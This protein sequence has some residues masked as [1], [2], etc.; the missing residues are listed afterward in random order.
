M[1]IKYVFDSQGFERKCN[2]KDIIGRITALN[3]VESVP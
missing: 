2:Q 1:V 3:D